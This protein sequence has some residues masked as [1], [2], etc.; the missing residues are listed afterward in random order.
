MKFKTPVVLILYNRPQK[1]LNLI[2][3]IKKVKP[4]KVFLIIDGPKNTKSD[5]RSCQKV[6]KVLKEINW[7]CS[8]NFIISKKNLGLKKRVVTG[9]NLVFQKVSTAIILEDDCKPN[10]SFFY[11]SEFL[12]KKFY[13][14]KKISG[15]SGNKFNSENVEQSIYFSKFF[16]I[17]GWATWARYWKKFDVNIKF[18]P[19]FK[20][21][22]KWIERC[23]DIVEREYWNSIFEKVYNNQINSWA[24]SNLLCSWYYN[25]LTV[26]PKVNLVSN[27]G[28]GLNATNTK[29]FYSFLQ[30]KV[31]KIKFPLIL[32]KIV[33]EN[34]ILDRK[35]FLNVYSGG[36]RRF[37]KPY[38]YI[39][40]FY[41]TIKNL[42]NFKNFYNK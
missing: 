28:F 30:P 18:W 10:K 23:P 16:S 9:L 11:F 4:R 1:A 22:K 15:I 41:Y 3:I 14:I 37:K 40:R 26:V 17:W 38:Y 34:K 19:K 33:E 36:S 42:L 25:T 24:Y 8:K 39:F 6:I 27:K 35:D 12:L 13:N 2:N 29:N 20:N 31:K 5:K 32:P 7:K 21:S